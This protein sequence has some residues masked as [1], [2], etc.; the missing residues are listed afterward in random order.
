MIDGTTL[1]VVGV[2]AQAAAPARALLLAIRPHLRGPGMLASI[3]LTPAPSTPPHHAGIAA[4]A[5]PA[6]PHR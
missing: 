6:T 4:I 1:I 3:A 5:A 2:V